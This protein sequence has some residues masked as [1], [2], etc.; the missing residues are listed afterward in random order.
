MIGKKCMGLKMGNKKC[1]LCKSDKTKFKFTFDGLDI[2]LNKMGISDFELNWYEC[3]SCGVYFSEQYENIEKVYEDETLYDAA[4]DENEIKIR[5][6]KIINLPEAG[7][8]NAQRVKRCKEYHK[9][10][11]RL[12]GVQKNTY[13]VLDIGAGL[14]VFV[15]K[16][17]DEHYICSA[18]ELNKVATA[19]I[20]SAMPSTIVYQD[21]TQ[22]L[23]FQN[24]FDIITL[25][26]VL[27]HIKTPIN[28]L[29]DVYMALSENGMLYLEL[30]DNFS[31]AL[32]G[33]SNEAFSS[34]HY[35]VYNDSSI[36][37]LF[38]QTGFRL[39][40]LE[41]LKEPSGKYTIYAI[42]IKNEIL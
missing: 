25:N 41:R 29:S 38:R 30:P 42:G 3:D 28:V 35:M 7:S 24:A 39:M 5:Y 33:S 15:A 6:E 10:L 22:N 31:F 14:G 17:A 16:F 11:C 4:Y 27:E 2:Y 19:H 34:G 23:N 36:M 13:D 20:K 1:L 18:L 37:Y 26:R 21:Y 9:G 40:K 8:D 12:H 32:D